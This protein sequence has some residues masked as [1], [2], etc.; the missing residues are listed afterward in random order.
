MP[1]RTDEGG[2]A[3]VTESS[4]SVLRAD[5]WLHAYTNID[6]SAAETRRIKAAIKDAYFPDSAT[7]REMV[8]FRARQVLR[9]ARDGLA[10]T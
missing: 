7:W 5:H 2:S 10:R 6:W 3:A 9:Q 8:L 4:P 1:A